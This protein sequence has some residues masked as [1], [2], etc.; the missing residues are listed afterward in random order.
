M[1]ALIQHWYL[2]AIAV[3]ALLVAWYWLDQPGM[4]P[5]EIDRASVLVELESALRHGDPSLART[6]ARRCGA[7]PESKMP[8]REPAFTLEGLEVE[9]MPWLGPRLAR[10]SVRLE[11]KTETKT[12]RMRGRFEYGWQSTGTTR[13]TTHGKHVSTS[14]VVGRKA[15]L[16]GLA[17]EG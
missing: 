13:T 4:P 5:D 6:L 10:G 7:Y 16:V 2:A 14:G 9:P 11:L 15:R 12:C 3:S 8:G 1:R 17:F